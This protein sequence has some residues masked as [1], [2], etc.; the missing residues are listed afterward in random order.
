M[1]LKEVIIQYSLITVTVIAVVFALFFG[2]LFVSS[3]DLLHVQ[4]QSMEPTLEDG[5]ILI[6]N[7]NIEDVENGDIVVYEDPSKDKYIVHRIIQSNDDAYILKGD[8]ND[9]P[10]KPIEESYIFA[11]VEV[12]IQLNDSI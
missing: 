9:Y 4:G 5:D 2:F 8:N 10:D 7:E 11:E 6:I 3:Y 12:R 1:N